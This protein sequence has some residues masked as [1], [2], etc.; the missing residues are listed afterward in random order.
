MIFCLWLM[1]IAVLIAVI[2]YLW[3]GYLRN[4]RRWR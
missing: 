3:V 2:L 1:V 4:P